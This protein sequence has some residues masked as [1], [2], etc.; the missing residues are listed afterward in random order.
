[1]LAAG[2]SPRAHHRRAYLRIFFGGLLLWLAAAI[3]TFLTQNPNLVPTVILLGSFVVPVTF[4]AWAFEHRTSEAL[5]EHTIFVGFVYGGVLGVLGASILEAPFAG[6]Q[7]LFSYVGV[8]LVEEACKLAALWF[9][10]RRMTAHSPR[11]GIVLG[12]AVGFGFA[13]FETAGY[14]FNAL[15][16]PRG[17]SLGSLVETQVLRGVLTPVGHGLWTGILGGVLFRGAREVRPHLSRALVGWYVLVSL[18]HAFWDASQG[19][20]FLLVVLFTTSTVQM[21]LL[22]QGYPIHPSS[23]QLTEMTVLNW[24]FFALDALVGILALRHVWRRAPNG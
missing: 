7:S 14:S 4:V 13:A 20:A 19:I 11:D 6:N 15:L 10:A 8:G 23:A 16:T 12:A 3:V 9:V 21:E 24:A 2:T 17:L 5:T 18:L 22:Q 1:M